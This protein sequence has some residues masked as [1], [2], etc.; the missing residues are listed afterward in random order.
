MFPQ[1]SLNTASYLVP[2]M[3]KYRDF[4]SGKD[5]GKPETT[6]DFLSQGK[7]SKY[8]YWVQVFKR[9][10]CKNSFNVIISPL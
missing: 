8:P 7:S 10:K 4:Q 6:L 9:Y 2:K 5:E 1:K 3:K